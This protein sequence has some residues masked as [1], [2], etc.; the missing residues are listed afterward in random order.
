[1]ADFYD[2]NEWE[3]VTGSVL[4]V[5]GQ[6]TMIPSGMTPSNLRIP[7]GKG[8]LTLTAPKTTTKFAEKATE[9][10]LQAKAVENLLRSTVAAWKT[11]REKSGG[12]GRL[13]GIKNWVAGALG[14]QSPKVGVEENENVV[15]FKGQINETASALAK[16][17]N[18]S[19][20]PGPELIGMF[21]ET[22][23]NIASSDKEMQAQIRDSL[24]SAYSRAFAAQGKTYDKETRAKVD[25]I[26]DNVINTPSYNKG[27]KRTIT[28]PS[29]KKI[30]IGG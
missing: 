10:D 24:H 19:G 8:S 18:P 7:V 3:D 13:Y 9:I 25:K 11:M 15:A 20:R 2:P 29:G 23:P 21:K 12:S 6:A 4:G 28:L 27:E 14:E 5:G 26:V 17:A 30:V 16:I 1:M 22:L